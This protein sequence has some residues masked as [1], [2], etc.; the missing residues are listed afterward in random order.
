M[1]CFASWQLR[2]F[3]NSSARCQMPGGAAPL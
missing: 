3:S 1:C 2:M